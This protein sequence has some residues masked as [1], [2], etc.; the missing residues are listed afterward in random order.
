MIIQQTL[1]FLRSHDG[2]R[3]DSL[4]VE[5]VRIGPYLTAVKLSDGSAGVASTL[6][7]NSSHCHRNKRRFGE[8]SP[9]HIRHRHVTDLLLSDDKP[10][11]MRSLQLAALNA[12]SAP[13][14]ENGAHRVYYDT[15]PVDM[16]DLGE[17]KQIVMVGAFLS[18]IRKLVAGNHS[19]K[20]LEF[21]SDALAPEHRALFVSSE[22][23]SEVIPDA[24]LV[25]ITGMTLLNQTA[26]ELLGMTGR[27]QQV[28]VTG[29]S[30]GIIP[31]VLFDRNVGLIG[32][33]LVT[34]ADRLLDLVGEAGAGYHLFHYCARKICISPGQAI[35]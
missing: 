26:D 19:L 13:W 11:L 4:V 33:T 6:S 10:P 12:L 30:G 22:K 17:G 31:D 34:D 9:L 3:M 21:S 15:D 16:L 20:V 1:D 24:D 7:D 29:P 32:A 25:I 35:F 14:I 5:D 23:A 28:V 2:E 8:F 27:H 18:Y